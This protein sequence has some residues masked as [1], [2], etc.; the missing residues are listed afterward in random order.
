MKAAVYKGKQKLTIE[1]VDTPI[2]GPNE[3]LIKVKYSALCGTDVHAFLYDI[4]SP[5]TVM[6]HEFCGT[7]SEV[8]S[9]VTA[10]KKNDRVVGGGGTPPP[11]KE[12][13][14]KV[15]PRY[16]FRTQGFS[17]RMRAYAEYVILDEWGPIL[18]PDGVS[19][20]EAALCEPTSVGVHAVRKSGMQLGDSAVIFGAGPIGLFCTQV[21]KATGA[22]QVIVFEP[23]SVRAN[24]ALQVGADTVLNPLEID[25]ISTAVELTGGIGPDV[26]F[27]CAGINSTLDQS[28]NMVRRNGKVILVAVIWE[29]I[30]L[31]PVDWS[32]REVSM[33]VSFSSDPSDW[34]AALN[35]FQS[36]KVKIGPMLSRE[37]IIPL[38]D[39][40]GAFESLIKPTTQLQ[41]V[42]KP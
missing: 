34:H 32:A 9:D 28:L 20:E 4:P 17:G 42:V 22:S 25:P 39:I 27:D 13:A 8:G 33:H 12:P 19:D 6:G 30:S 29:K 23:S 38:T 26:V 24:A 41:L 2:P 35:L 11:G 16:N 1:E 18:I 40:Q 3:V 21:A 31:L 37:Q 7:I 10:W 14:I 36:G 5:G 15:G